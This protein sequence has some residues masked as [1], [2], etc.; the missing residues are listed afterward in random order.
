MDYHEHLESLE[1]SLLEFDKLSRAIV[2]TD[3]FLEF[4]S[5]ESMEGADLAAAE[6]YLGVLLEPVGFSFESYSFEDSS[7]PAS[8]AAVANTSVN[9][10][11]SDSNKPSKG[12]KLKKFAKDSLDKM[13]N[14][15]KNLPEEIKKY[16]QLLVDTMTNSTKG[17]SNSAKQI[18]DKLE[19]SE[20]ITGKIKGSYSIFEEVRPQAALGHIGK[21]LASLKSEADKSVKQIIGTQGTTSNLK[22]YNYKG[23]EFVFDGTSKFFDSKFKTEKSEI[24]A[25]SKTDIKL[26]CENVIKVSDAVEDLKSSLPDMGKY[27]DDI[28]NKNFSS[29]SGLKEVGKGMKDGSKTAMSIAGFYRTVIGGYVKYTIKVSK[30]ALACANGSIKS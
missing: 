21:G 22:L 5:V 3:A 1:N 26:V 18:L 10:S 29:G 25:L 15:L 27:V 12:E 30:V 23:T 14:K 19:S 13:K 9:E 8:D 17:L 24:N 7:T 4:Y 16:S 28:V 2:K 11:S 6:H 20:S